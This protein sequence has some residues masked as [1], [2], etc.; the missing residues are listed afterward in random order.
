MVTHGTK[1]FEQGKEQIFHH[2]YGWISAKEFYDLAPGNEVI[3]DDDVELE[4]DYMSRQSG[5]SFEHFHHRIKDMNDY[6]EDD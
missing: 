6:S 2:T 1:R 5:E 4:P 3:S